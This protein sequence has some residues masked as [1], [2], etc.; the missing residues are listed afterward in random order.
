MK[1]FSPLVS[2]IMPVFNGEAFLK[3]AIDSVLV[4]TYQNIEILVVN[5]GSTDNSEKIIK[6]YSSKI[7]YFKKVNGGVATALNLA[8]KKAK[9]KYIS[10]LSHDDLYYPNK[11]KKQIDTLSK[12]PKKDQENTIIYSNY[13]V[14]DE[15]SNHIGEFIFHRQHKIR[16]LNY[17]LYPLLNGLIHGCSLLI[18]K[19]CFFETRLF[20][21]NLKNT[22]DYDLWFEMFPK[23][24]MLYLPEILIK[25]RQHPGQATNSSQIYIHEC[26]IL[27]SKMIDN[28]S[29]EQKIT[30]GGSEFEFNKNMFIRLI[31][32]KLYKAAYE[33]TNNIT[34]NSKKTILAI[35]T[36]YN[37]GDIIEAVIKN[38]LNQGI[39]VYIVDNWSDDGSYE[40]LSK[41][42]KE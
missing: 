38:L 32:N 19:K 11:I 12:I 30:V 3:E 37:E 24:T 15:K 28:L 27:W 33:L 4:Q 16:N 13:E 22:Q 2:I 39:D 8:I 20:D 10:W 40:I 14:I 21:I 1:K 25:S 18:P 7:R 23:Y 35:I 36:I 42:A 6:S 41:L 5:D 26:N 9:G 29:K 17:P 34:T 31:N